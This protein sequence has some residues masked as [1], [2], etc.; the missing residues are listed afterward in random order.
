MMLYC[1]GAFGEQHMKAPDLL[2]QREQDGGRGKCGVPDLPAMVGAEKSL[3]G[4]DGR[5]IGAHGG[6]L[7]PRECLSKVRNKILD[8]LNADGDPDHAG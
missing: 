7:N 2:K 3:D 6:A 4:N 8:P 5:N 1:F